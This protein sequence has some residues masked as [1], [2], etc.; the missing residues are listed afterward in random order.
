MWQL[1]QKAKNSN[2]WKNHRMLWNS[3][4][5]GTEFKKDM[6]YK[7]Q[8]YYGMNGIQKTYDNKD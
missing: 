5:Q 6:D 8:T 4:I 1:Y 3:S 2:K 7:L